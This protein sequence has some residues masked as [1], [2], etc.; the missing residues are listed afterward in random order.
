MFDLP[1]VSKADKKEYVRFRNYLLDQGFSMSQYSV[2]FRFLSSKDRV[3]RFEKMI[4]L[5]LPRQGKVQILTI[6]DKQYENIKAY[7]GNEPESLKK[8]SQFQLF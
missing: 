1:T 8:T 5:S 7:F 4:A 2:Y 6:T 3:Q